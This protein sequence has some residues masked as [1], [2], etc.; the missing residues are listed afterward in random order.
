M[1]KTFWQF[2]GLCAVSMTVGCASGNRLGLW[3]HTTPEAAVIT[4]VTGKVLG[5]APLFLSYDL[6]DSIANQPRIGL[7]PL[8]ATWVDG[9]SKPTTPYV[10]LR[11]WTPSRLG[12][13]RRLDREITIT[14]DY[15]TTLP[16]AQPTYRPPPPQ[17]QQQ[18]AN[19]NPSKTNDSQ[20]TGQINISSSVA[21]ARIYVDGALVGSNSVSLKLPE[22]NHILE[23]KSSGYSTYKREIRIYAETVA[24][25]KAT[26]TK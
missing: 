18:T 16:N 9:F 22:G 7:N 5:R 10:E 24:T 26:L 15:Y 25:L 20:S 12:K 1:W 21:D 14:R 6:T 19:L 2:C 3:V 8:T 17:Q 11:D 4:D 23:I 13:G